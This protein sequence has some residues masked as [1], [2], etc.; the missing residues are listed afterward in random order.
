[1][2]LLI[3]T[4]LFGICFQASAAFNNSSK[5]ALKDCKPTSNDV[6]SGYW[7]MSKSLNWYGKVEKGYDSYTTF[8]FFSNKKAWALNRHSD[9]KV[10]NNSVFHKLKYSTKNNVLTLMTEKNALVGKY[11]ICKQGLA[12]FDADGPVAVYSAKVD[13]FAPIDDATTNGKNKR[14]LQRPW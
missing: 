6:T 1:M 4:L 11:K 12:R 5:G 8:K 7:T 3:I 9:R 14:K 10:A 13:K 2:K